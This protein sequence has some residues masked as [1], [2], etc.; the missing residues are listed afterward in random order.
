LSETSNI[1]EIGRKVANDIFDV[2]G[3]KP[4][5]PKDHN[6]DCAT[7]REHERPTHPSDVVFWYEDPYT[8]QKIYLNTDL[9]SWKRDT[10]TKSKIRGDLIS[11]CQ[12]V[13]CANTS[14][15][16][17]ALYGDNTT[18]YQVH[19]LLFLF[20][21]DGLL[22]TDVSRMLAE[23]EPDAF[24]L[25]TQ[26]RIFV[27]TP[28]TIIYLAAV[29]NDIKVSCGT[30]DL[31]GLQRFKF[32]YPDLVDVRPR[33]N[34]RT[35]A[36]A[37]MLGGPWQVLRYSGNSGKTSRYQVGYYVYYRGRGDSEDEY[38]YLIDFFFRYQ[39]LGDDEIISLRMPFASQEA[40]AVFMRAKDSYAAEF[41]NIREFRE[42]LE[43]ITFERIQVVSLDLSP[44]DEGI[45]NG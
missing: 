35:V 44:T 3:W 39:L 13:E 34:E 19:G 18:S 7:P 25:P 2:F 26:K 14:P 10:F 17:A 23:Y 38:K 36:T 12:A 11:L 40:K 5:G 42:R 20:N 1:A 21:R 15:S 9:K 32:Y 30:G 33:S 22:E 8:N 4:V 43:R 6:F 41:F 27:F 16:W 28:Q 29:A 37:E 31:P 24:V 45:P